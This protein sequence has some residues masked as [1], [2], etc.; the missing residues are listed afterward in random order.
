MA[1]VA[2]FLTLHWAGTVSAQRGPPGER[3]PDREAMQ[4]RI[5]ERFGEIVRRQLGLDRAAQ[6]ALLEAVRE[7]ERER[8]TLLGRE[9]ELR[10]Q[11]RE[12]VE[13]APLRD[14][15]PL[16]EPAEARELL[17]EMAAIREAELRLFRAEQERLLQ[18][19]TP[20]QL[21][22]FYALREDLA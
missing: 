7:S 18:V 14:P 17:R 3:G 2:I 15:S 19:L 1:L 5:R 6:Q 4:E 9:M 8:R 11:L 13:I 16:L 22:R 21:V 20:P 12:Q 10:K